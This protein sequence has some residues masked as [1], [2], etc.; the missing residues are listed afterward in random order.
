MNEYRIR[1]VRLAVVAGSVGVLAIGFGL[2][3]SS[4]ATSRTGPIVQPTFSSGPAY[5]AA[6]DRCALSRLRNAG[7][8][9]PSP[10]YWAY[11]GAYGACALGT[12]AD[13]IASPAGGWGQADPGYWAP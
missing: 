12:D 9:D 10:T 3:A 13:I 11:G 5:E 8:Q 1:P 2:Y 6:M 7:V 4:H